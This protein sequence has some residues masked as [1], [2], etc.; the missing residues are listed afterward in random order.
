MGFNKIILK[1]VLSTLAAVLILCGALVLSLM[2][3][4]PATMMQLSYDLGLDAASIQ[5][6]N[7]AYDRSGEKEIYYIAFAT[8]VAIGLKDSEDIEACAEKLIQNSEFETYCAEK[9]ESINAQGQYAQYYYG[10]LYAAKYK[11]GK[12]QEAIDGAFS[13]LRGGFP[14]NNAVGV[15]LLSALNASDM[16]SVEKISQMLD[17]ASIDETALSNAEKIYL[18]QVRSILQTQAD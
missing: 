11:N 8:E 18:E 15:V 7:T 2:Y 9:D 17:A 10:Q 5:Y 4:Y 16:P 1:A 14:A 12:T 6:A 3:I 13:S